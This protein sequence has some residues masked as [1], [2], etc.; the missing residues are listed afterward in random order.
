MG[1]ERRIYTRAPFSFTAKVIKK[2][3]KETLVAETRNIGAGGI[4]V[5]L[6]RN[7]GLFNEVLVQINFQDNINAPIECEG[8]IVWVLE[9]SASAQGAEK[10]FDTGI[11]FTK[12]KEEDKARIIRA[13]QQWSQKKK[14]LR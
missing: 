5:S 3:T 12:V 1:I 11:E 14:S 7:F 13:V 9:D 4:C 6:K 8:R 2:S 10:S